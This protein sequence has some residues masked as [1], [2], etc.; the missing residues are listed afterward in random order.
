MNCV[1]CK[2]G[3]YTDG[4]ATV[5]LTKYGSVV[6]VKNVPAKVCN[7]CGEYILDAATSRRILVLAQEAYAKGS[8]VEIYSFAA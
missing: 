6:I 1:I 8:E 5:V 2:S 4:F 7:Q 3:I